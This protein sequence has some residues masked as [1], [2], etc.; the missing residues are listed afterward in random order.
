[1]AD[2]FISY[3]QGSPEATQD[4]AVD[5][6]SKGYTVWFDSRLLP[7]DV[8]WKVIRD[9]IRAAKAVV[10]IWSPRAVESEWVY[11]EAKMAHEM[12]KL[13]CVRTP[14]VAAFDVPMP[15][16]GM[17][18]APVGE[19]AKIYE[20][21]T[22][23][24][25]AAGQSAPLAKEEREVT[26]VTVAW[27]EAKASGNVRVIEAFI[28][29]YRD[30][31]PFFA[32]L[33]EARLEELS[34][35]RAGVVVAKPA[36]AEIPLPKEG[37]VFLRIE[38]GMHT[39]PIDCIGVNAAATLMITGS[40][41]KTARL[42]A[43]KSGCG[44]PELLRTF[45][46]PIGEGND[47]KIYAV[48]L[49][50]DGTWVA[51]G[52][53]D[54]DAY[55]FEAATGRLKTRLCRLDNGI[56]HFALSL[57]GGF[58]AAT[59]GGGAGMRLWETAGWHLIAE[60][61]DY[62]DHS[63]GAGF[64]NANRLYTVADD[65]LIRRYSADG[66]LEAKAA[67]RGGKMPW[68]IAVHPKGGM[69]AI[70]FYDTTAVEVYEAVTLQLLYAA[71]T[72]G[73]TDGNLGNVAWSYDGA[74]LYAGGE[75][76]SGSISP[77]VIWQDEGRGKREQAPV[78]HNTVMQLLP[79]GDGMAVGTGDPAFGLIA[80]D[81]AKR[82]WQGGDI[83]DVRN[84]QRDTPAVSDDGK[85]VHFGLGQDAKEPLVFDLA[86]FELLNFSES[87]SGLTQP[88]TS[89]IAVSD[90]KNHFEPKQNGKPLALDDY[91]VSRALAIAPDAS[92]F[93]LGTEFWLRAYRADGAELWK[94]PVSGI[95]YGVNING[96]GTTVI[97]AL[98]DGTI[99][100]HRLSD[101]EELLALFVH[102]KDRR[103]IAWTPKGYYAASPG[104]EDLIGWH[105]NRGF[106]TAPD[107]YPASTFASTF[108]RPDI[109][110]AALDI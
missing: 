58:L 87:Q 17:N 8:F 55:I 57:D 19:R 6:A 83:A 79:C 24:G 50:P 110:K 89:G 12:K 13:I 69:L 72:S 86:S 27:G 97:T 43:L 23:L 84:I 82:I 1:L 21:L 25:L 60:D 100:W 32:V 107:F 16:N 34:A 49:S 106:D 18:V 96:D 80:A 28:A 76:Q 46:V 93:V 66:H 88:K 47:G 63:S 40:H 64:D 10:V 4:L 51:A 74:R 36:A 30:R 53:W 90:W 70:G 26:E 92:R 29:H 9:E 99:R 22:K 59:F 109:V 15:F 42:W 14:D 7:M 98:H 104:A 78:S 54:L 61:K 105:V 71:D 85:L 44:G 94:K 81:G 35:A 38:P 2:I 39:A 37:D 91:E 20:A 75:Y 65:G 5:L 108:N 101:G 52:G 95:A 3:S 68:S 41:D 48:A 33:A 31:H 62:G 73:I 56:A 103:Y 67:T 102:A 11:A 45:R 77:I